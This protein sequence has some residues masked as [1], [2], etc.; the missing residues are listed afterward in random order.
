VLYQHIYIAQKLLI[1]LFA[2]SRMMFLDDGGR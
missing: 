2:R 1:A